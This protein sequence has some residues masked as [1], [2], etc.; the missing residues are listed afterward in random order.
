MRPRCTKCGRSGHVADTCF[1]LQ[2]QANNEKQPSAEAVA[3]VAACRSD[4][5][6]LAKAFDAFAQAAVERVLARFTDDDDVVEICAGNIGDTQDG[7]S[8]KSIARR[9][10]AAAREK[11][12]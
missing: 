7:Q 10:L 11:L 2:S 6:L 1:P 12:R 9:V 8:H 5:T 4:S 3:L